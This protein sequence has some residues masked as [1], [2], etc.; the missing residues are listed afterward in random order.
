MNHSQS[1][2]GLLPETMT[3]PSIN[4][5]ADEWYILGIDDTPALAHLL[6]EGCLGSKYQD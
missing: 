3:V 1:E 4:K 2:L 6:P 5:L